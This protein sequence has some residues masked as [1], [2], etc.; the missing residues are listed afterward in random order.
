MTEFARLQIDREVPLNE[1]AATTYDYLSRRAREKVNRDEWFRTVAEARINHLSQVIERAGVALETTRSEKTAAVIG[2][3]ECDLGSCLAGHFDRPTLHYEPNENGDIEVHRLYWDI[4]YMPSEF[5]VFEEGTWKT[6]LHH[7]E[8]FA[9][10]AT[11]CGTS[12]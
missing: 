4:G 9:A 1:A 11:T 8:A 5:W 6:P 2:Q 7:T 3:A 12:K 10:L